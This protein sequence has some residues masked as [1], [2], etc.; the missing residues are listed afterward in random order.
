H[1]GG[2]TTNHPTMQINPSFN[3]RESGF[4][5]SEQSRYE[6]VIYNIICDEPTFELRQLTSEVALNG[7]GSSQL[8]FQT[9]T[10]HLDASVPWIITRAVQMGVALRLGIPVL[11]VAHNPFA[12]ALVERKA[13]QVIEGLLARHA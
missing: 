5:D 13:T 10:V 9:G 12:L 3:R 11:E 4:S 7:D 2:V 8:L 6:T 1:E